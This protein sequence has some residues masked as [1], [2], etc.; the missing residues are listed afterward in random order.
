MSVWVGTRKPGKDM[1]PQF[2]T[3]RLVALAHLQSRLFSV[4]RPGEDGGSEPPEWVIRV[5]SRSNR[6]S[7]TYALPPDSDPPSSVR[8]PGYRTREPRPPARRGRRSGG[9]GAAPRSEEEGLG[10]PP[11]WWLKRADT[12]DCKRH[13]QRDAKRMLPGGC[14]STV[15]GVS[16]TEQAAAGCCPR[17]Q[18]LP[19]EWT[20]R[21][22]AGTCGIFCVRMLARV[23]GHV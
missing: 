12:P 20:G 18:F 13:Q 16:A 10:N 17:V 19:S 4:L 3:T 5:N 8:S 15:H 21:A 11:E 22:G 1:K 6:R 9:R 14:Y 2:T 23:T 7:R